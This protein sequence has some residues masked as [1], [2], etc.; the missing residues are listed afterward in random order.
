MKFKKIKPP[1]YQQYI[2]IYIYIYIITI[3]VNELNLA[4]KGE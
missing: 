3:N 4:L 2:Y 1:V